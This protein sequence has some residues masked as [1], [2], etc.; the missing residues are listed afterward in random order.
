MKRAAIG[1]RTHSGWGAL[2]AVS[3]DAGA[4]DV[5]QRQHVA[6]NFSPRSFSRTTLDQGS[7]NGDTCRVG[8]SGKQARVI[9]A[10]R[11]FEEGLHHGK[12]LET[13]HR[14]RY[15]SATFRDSASA[16]T[17]ARLHKTM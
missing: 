11:R 17:S 15:K 1:V 3:N 8:S 10:N 14:G 7:E 6:T 13:A 16:L 4:V 9:P 2:V 12:K 5:I